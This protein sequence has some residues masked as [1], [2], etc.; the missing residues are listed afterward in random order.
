MIE[1]DREVKQSGGYAPGQARMKR[2]LNV[3]LGSVV[4]ADNYGIFFGE[5]VVRYIYG[6]SEKSKRPSAKKLATELQEKL[7]F[8]FSVVPSR[9][10]DPEKGIPGRATELVIVSRPE[11]LEKIEYEDLKSQD[12]LFD[13]A[14]G[15]RLDRDAL[16]SDLLKAA[17]ERTNPNARDEIQRQIE[18]LNRQPLEEFLPLLRGMPEAVK[19]VAAIKNPEGRRAAVIRLR[20]TRSYPQPFY[21]AAHNS[22]RAYAIGENLLYLHEPVRRCLVDAHPELAE[23]DIPKAQ[24]RIAATALDLQLLREALETSVDFW[25]DT[26]TSKL[27]GDG[28]DAKRLAKSSSYGPLYG[29][30]MTQ[31]R[32]RLIYGEDAARKRK[33]GE[34]LRR[35]I[36]PAAADAVLKSEV[37]QELFQAS[38]EAIDSL[39]SGGHIMNGWDEPVGIDLS[40]GRHA[41]QARSRLAAA[42]QSYEVRALLAAGQ[43][44]K[45]WLH[46]GLW[47]GP[48]H[49]E[50]VEEL[51]EDEC[52]RM[53]LPE[54]RGGGASALV[55]L[56]EPEGLNSAPVPGPLFRPPHFG[57]SDKCGGLNRS[58]ESDEG[59]A[60]SQIERFEHLW[61]ELWG[62][63]HGE[64]VCA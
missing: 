54:I 22:D 29:S 60:P 62:A 11:W 1:L 64:P 20:G 15:Q 13:Y 35:Q 49:R 9:L 33:R 30:S 51:V 56:P 63:Q 59:A 39:R 42:F 55:A 28:Y 26:F 44:A 50:L 14:T 43:F 32:F 8:Q 18:L 16:R 6:W 45:L 37:L 38:K 4:K 24:L 34:P 31:T 48:E 36:D 53:N 5:S 40:Q 61:A 2:A 12:D 58:V 46:D 57:V 47:C 10:A 7:G 27:G 3:L 25:E 41:A 19:A 23:Y 17:R 52:K 21:F